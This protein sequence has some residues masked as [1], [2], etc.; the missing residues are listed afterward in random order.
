M[1]YI[2]AVHVLK[3]LKHTHHSHQHIFDVSRMTR[4][5]AREMHAILLP[6]H[7]K[8]SRELD[9]QVKRQ[10]PVVPETYDRQACLTILLSTLAGP[11]SPQR[12]VLA[13]LCLDMFPPSLSKSLPEL[14]HLLR[15]M[16]LLVHH[17][18]LLQTICETSFM[19][20]TDELI[21]QSLSH[22]YRHHQDLDMLQSY[23][24]SLCD[25]VVFL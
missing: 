7:A 17:K 5:L 13:S 14:R 4:L 18:S 2:K 20:W 23:L 16:S 25:S 24:D 10:K 8:C 3:Q 12:L 21:P 6:L 22:F 1:A 19:Y 9:T 11:V 15:K